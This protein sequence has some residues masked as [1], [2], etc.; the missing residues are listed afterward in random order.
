MKKIIISMK[1]IFI[2]YILSFILIIVSALIYNALGH[3]NIDNFINNYLLYILVIYY[4]IVIIYL[5]KKNKLQEKNFSKHKIFPLISL[6]ISLS[7]LLNMIIFKINPPQTVNAISIPM[8]IMTTGI[9]GPIYEEILFRY[10]LYNRL[11][12][13]YQYKKALLITTVIFA[14]THLNPIKILYAFILGLTFNY[15][16][17]KENNI[18]APILIH[19]SAN[20]MSIFL[21]E[22]NTYLLLL[23]I[24]YLL[25]SIKLISKNKKRIKK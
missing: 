17:E 14:L 19:T 4:L 20:I 1:E 16:Y 21:Y 9:I 15:I 13:I 3:S 25:I 12:N 2:T 23:S 24:I 5:Y 6:G 8:A 22:Y 18:L 11:K 7:V 10:L